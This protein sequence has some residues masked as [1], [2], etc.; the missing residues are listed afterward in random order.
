VNHSSI[1]DRMRDRVLA[2]GA[3]VYLLENHA[4][5][6]VDVVG[7]FEGGLYLEAPE[8][9]GVADLTLAMLDRGTRRRS[10]NEIAI[11]LE[12]NAIRLDYSLV[13]EGAAVRGRCL[14]EDLPLLLELM[15]EMLAEPSF[16]EE[17]L[18]L[19]KEQ[20]LVDLRQA[21]YDTF[22]QATRRAASL[23]LGPRH[24]YAR[25]PQGEPE[26]VPALTRAD[27]DAYRRRALTA[28]RLSLAV[29]GD[30]DPDA[31]AEW[32]ARRL[33]A[34][35]GEPPPARP[36]GGDATTA[37]T[38]AAPAWPGIPG[39][40][41]AIPGEPGPLAP[42]RG[43]G[44]VREHVPLSDKEQIDLVFLRPGVART[45]SDFENYG[46]ANFILGGSFI[47]RLN[48][49]LRDSAGLTY[50]ASSSIVSGRSPGCWLA[51]VGVH[52]RDLE[53]AIEMV[54]EELARFA[55]EGVGEEELAVARDHLT[56]AFPLRLETNRSVAALF[57]DGIRYGR[58]RD[59][60]SRYVDCLRAVDRPRVDAAARRLI[61]PEEMVIVSCGSRAGSP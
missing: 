8:Q 33:D 4:D 42:L 21:A 32:L 50:G 48:H 36:A 58:G 30:I 26:I 16:P 43:R 6:T 34:L 12:S 41:E 28:P 18:A 52:P 11:A 5:V 17:Q 19:A 54:R 55:G 10:E 20:A 45:T 60:L 27:L 13:R 3:R 40:G 23:L 37:A 39:P 35:P 47:S 53:R 57:L 56:G 22:E 24:P 29:V 51:N 9:S 49:R 31:T 44:V 38:Q 25:E 2:N 15:G 61:D 1:A 46:V 59:Y 14:S 7:F